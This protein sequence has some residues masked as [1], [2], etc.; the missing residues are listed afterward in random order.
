MNGKNRPHWEFRHFPLERLELKRYGYVY[1]FLRLRLAQF[2]ISVLPSDGLL[3]FLTIFRKIHQ[4]STFAQGIVSAYLWPKN[5][6]SGGLGAPNPN[7]ALQIRG[8]RKSFGE[9]LDGGW[10]TFWVFHPWKFGKDPTRNGGE[11]KGQIWGF[12]LLITPALSSTRKTL[13]ADDENLPFR[14]VHFL[15]ILQ[16]SGWTI[17]T[18]D[19]CRPLNRWGGVTFLRP[20]LALF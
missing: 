20:S 2:P 19:L 6:I 17:G 9:S 15:F 10:K 12:K 3:I 16:A 7:F 14:Q 11:I 4:N 1:I 8:K 13:D 18:F 5:P